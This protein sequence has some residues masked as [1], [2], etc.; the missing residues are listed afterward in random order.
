M[1]RNEVI[2]LCIVLV[3]VSFFTVVSFFVISFFLFFF[4]YVIMKS[5]VIDTDDIYAE[6]IASVFWLLVFFFCFLWM[7]YNIS[8]ERETA[9][10]W[11]CLYVRLPLVRQYILPLLDFHHPNPHSNPLLPLVLA[12]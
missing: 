6:A 3:M 5:L 8:T 4:V 10:I 12:R 11:L 2:L 9:I 7:L 1:P